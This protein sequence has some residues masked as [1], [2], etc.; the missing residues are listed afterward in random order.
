MAEPSPNPEQRSKAA[1]LDFRG[2]QLKDAP[3]LEALVKRSLG[4]AQTTP[5][6]IEAQREGELVRTAYP[7]GLRIKRRGQELFLRYD[8]YRIRTFQ[9]GDERAILDLFEVA[10]HHRRP[11]VE[12]KWKY[13]DNPWGNRRISVA[14]SPEGELV[15]QYCAY[16]VE[17]AKPP[18]GFHTQP[19]RVLAHQVGDT[20]TKQSVRAVGRGPTS[21]LARLAEHFYATWCQGEVAFNFGWNTGNIQKFSRRFVGAV[22]I[23]QA[24]Y[25]L[26]ERAQLEERLRATAPRSS[27]VRLLVGT[28]APELKVFPLTQEQLAKEPSLGRAIDRFANR[29]VLAHGQQVLRSARYLSWRYLKAPGAPYSARLVMRQDRVMGLVVF[30]QREDVL[31]IGE[32]QFDPRF[33]RQGLWLSLQDVLSSSSAGRF[34]GWFPDRPGTVRSLLLEFGFVPKPEPDDLGLVVVPFED[35][36]ATDHAKQW[37]YSLGDSDLF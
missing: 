5:V 13:E 8:G 7:M 1:T 15:G 14:L 19:V 23:E 17:L 11:A 27:L 30:R 2:R 6:L 3:E 12:W 26:A 4:E 33:A 16:P 18:R 25:L 34:E 31:R 24:P 22:F 9:P 32:A 10:F 35:N 36:K 29:Q 20:M 37:N 21:I 28:E